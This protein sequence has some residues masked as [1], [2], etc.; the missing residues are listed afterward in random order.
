MPGALPPLTG[1]VYAAARSA[2]MRRGTAAFT[3]IELLVVIAIIAILAAIL[4]PVFAKAREKARSSSCQSNVK[5]LMT[6]E[7]MYVQDNDET[8]SISYVVPGM[9][10]GGNG[11]NVNWWRFPLQPYIKNWQVFNCPSGRPDD[12]PASS[13]VQLIGNYGMTGALRGKTLAA[14]S[15]PVTVVCM[16][17]ALHW[18]G[19]LYAGMCYAYAGKASTGWFDASQAAN[20]I[21]ANTRHMAGSN[22]GFADG[23]VKWYQHSAIKSNMPAWVTP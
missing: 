19:D 8:F 4:F 3:L 6:C 13:T 9:P 18:D 10:Q 23:H 14:V 21:E 17:D 5:Q 15:Q 16:G 12:N 11:T 1:C 22:L 20:Q 7:L 2:L